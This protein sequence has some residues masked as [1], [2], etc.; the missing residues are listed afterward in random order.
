[1]CENEAVKFY[2]LA[3]EYCRFISESE[4]TID[5]V[6]YLIELLMKLYISAT[7]LPETDPETIDSLSPDSGNLSIKLEKQIS[8]TYWEVY[9]PYVDEQP[10]CG[11]LADDL[12]DI[13][14]DL[15]KGMREYEA[16]RFGNAVFE[17]KLG[18]NSHWGQHVVDALRALH[19]VRCQ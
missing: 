17:W 2:D 5:I 13:A 10:I 7:H 1:M 16:N 11:D 19:A 15:K 14:N 9:D 8:S 12:S 3:S 18:L 4:I 6:P